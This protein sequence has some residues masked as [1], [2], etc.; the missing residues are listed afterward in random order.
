[1]NHISSGKY[2]VYLFDSDTSGEKTYEEFFTESEIVQADIF[3]KLGFIS[4]KA[5][6]SRSE[7][8]GII[9]ELE[10]VLTSSNLTKQNIVTVLKRFIP[11][12]DHIEKGLSLDSKM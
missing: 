10:V 9:E 7:I 11:E 6:Y 4:K 1:M 2:P 12:F 3:K 5:Q 8:D